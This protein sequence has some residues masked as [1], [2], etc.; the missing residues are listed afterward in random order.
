MDKPRH[1]QGEIYANDEDRRNGL[2]EAKRRY[3]NKSWHC[4][5]CDISILRGDKSRHLKSRKHQRK[6]CPTCSESD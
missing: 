4:E 3:G 5:I 1:K 2:L 6:Q